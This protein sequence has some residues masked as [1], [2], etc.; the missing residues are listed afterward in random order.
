MKITRRLASW[1]KRLA[2]WAETGAKVWAACWLLII[3]SCLI[4]GSVF[5]KW[6]EFPFSRNLSG[7]ELPLLH[8]SGII[9][10]ITLF[11]FG[12][13]GVVVLI[14]GLVLL[15]F[16]VPALSLAAAV[17]LTLCVLVPAHIA[18]QQPI[19]L[20]RLADELQAMPL[21]KVFTKDYLPQNYGPTEDVPKQ[22]IL[23]TARGR[24]LAAY[25][26]LRLGWSCFALGS[27][28]IAIDAIRHLPGGRM[29]IVLALVCLPVGALAILLTPPIIGQH[30]FTRGSIAKAQG[31][32]QEAIADYRKAMRWDAWHAQ[33]IDLYATIGELQ[34]QTGIA[35]NSPE[36][37]MNRAVELQNASE[38]EPAIFEFSRA[39]E[40]GGA[41]ALAARRASA[42]TRVT[43]GLALYHA[44]GIGAAVSSWQL[45][46]ADDARQVY[47]LPY[48]ARG[49]YDVGR[50]EAALRT[51]DRLV[52]IV[53]DH[54]SMQGDAYSLG[55]DCYAKLGRDA[56]ARHYYNLSYAVDPL[57]NYWALT[58]LVGE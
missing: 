36:R 12:A 17:L 54:N 47:A 28:L 37:H 43:L 20:R 27:L 25:S 53:A 8:D 14:A 49:Y 32:N 57:E 23:Y 56:D 42:Q 19:M 40:A 58:G 21:I 51:I 7:L 18:F 38:Y 13:L 2:L 50:Y 52:Q 26:F 16:F 44:G 31:R 35:N 11:S 6:V 4:L 10:N 15:R 41:L 3:S 34:K 55:G 9:P 39:A 30:Y 48:L 1:A 33:D 46:L 5:L 22:L 45:A 29:A 24:F